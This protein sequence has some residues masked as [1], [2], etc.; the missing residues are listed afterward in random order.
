[1]SRASVSASRRRAAGR[2]GHRQPDGHAESLRTR[3]S[4]CSWPPSRPTC[5]PWPRRS[6][7]W[8]PARPWQCGRQPAGHLARYSPGPPGLPLE[9]LIQRRPPGRGA[10]GRVGIPIPGFGLEHAAAVYA[11]IALL[12]ALGGRQPWR[13][14]QTRARLARS[15]VV[16]LGVAA[17]VVPPALAVVAAPRLF[18]DHATRLTVDFAGSTPT[19]YALR[20]DESLVVAGDRIRPLR[21]GRFSADL[22]PHD[23]HTGHAQIRR[24]RQR[25]GPRPPVR[26]THST[27]GS[28][29]ATRAWRGSRF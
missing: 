28:P 26:A 7:S 5:W 4:A 17:F 25:R 10:A 2:H 13:I 29:A 14:P 18:Q 16:G 1:M 20:A 23:R 19:V 22:E 24:T 3:S 12:V 21:A 27:G 9:Y 11:A 15:L 8:P 6:G